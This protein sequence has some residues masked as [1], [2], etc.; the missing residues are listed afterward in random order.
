MEKIKDALKKRPVFS[1]VILFLIYI[2]AFF[3]EQKL[4]LKPVIWIHHPLD[5]VIPFCKY[6]LLPYC[7]WHIEFGL[8]LAYLYFIKKDMNEY[9]R[10]LTAIL[11]GLWA[12]LLVFLFL[13]NGINLRPAVVEGNDIFAIGTRFLYS[14]DDNKNVCP[15]IHVVGCVI[16][17]YSWM[18]SIESKKGRNALSFMNFMI[19]ISTVFMKQHSCVDVVIGFLFGY[20]ADALVTYYYTRER[21]PNY[22]Y[23]SKLLR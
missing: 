15:S 21:V 17:N 8:V 2:V 14:I 5:D 20:A 12:S 10:T 9:W 7:M 3:W 6:M 13:P 19:I 23:A 16:M 11:V 4:D 1:T 18:R 22:E